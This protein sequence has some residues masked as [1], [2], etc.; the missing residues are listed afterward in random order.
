MASQFAVSGLT[1]T[2]GSNVV[3]DQLD[4]EI[5]QGEFLVLLGPSGCGK[6]TTLRCLAGLETPQGGS[7]SFGGR[8]VFD[9][10]T[11]TDVPAHKRNIGMVFQSYALWPHM[12]VRDNIRYPL[13]VRKLKQAIAD[14]AVEKAAEMVDC[15]A[16]LDR[17]PSQLSGG[18]QQ[19]VAV[20]RG[21][22]AQPD[23]V[24]F[25]EPLSN[26]DARL[27]DQVRSQIH[28]LHQSLGFTAVFVTHDQA[29][30]F[31]L[32]DRIAIMKSGRIEQYDAPEHVFENPVSEYVAA[33]IGMGNRLELRR[34]HDG[35]N[36]SAN[37]V[38]DLS[39]A[40]VRDRADE[41]TAAVARFRPD[42]VQMHASMDDVP[43]GNVALHAE[44]VT[45]EYA[46]RHF[47]VLVKT[48]TEQ[49][50]LRASAAEHSATLRASDPGTPMVISFSPSSLRVY[51][52]PDAAAVT[53]PELVAPGVGDRS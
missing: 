47:D 38:I 31:A 29:E 45:Y 4:L 42:D 10:S 11:K 52:D 7:I 18:Q 20:A 13:K 28:Q 17:Y 39:N 12:T 15:G 33:F 53:V 23:L 43:A 25:D 35:W 16:L 6:T 50:A 37:D 9:A 44:L 48:G 34:A 14:G 1:K 21:L 22:V 40:S 19:R 26:L 51:A 32:A 27:R 49:L 30:A 2:Y 36:T 46:G 8:H 3:V 5:E 24:L 41:G